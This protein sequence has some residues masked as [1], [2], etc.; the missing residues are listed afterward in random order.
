MNPENEQD[1][2]DALRRRCWDSAVHCFGTSQIFLSRSKRLT[3]NLRLLT[4]LGLAAPLAVG[5]IVA[6]FGLQSTIAPLALA[7]AAVVGIFQVIVFAWSVVFSWVDRN[8]YAKESAVA[9]DDLSNRFSRLGATPPSTLHEMQAAVDIV[10][11]EDK[12]RR[13]RDS[14]AHMSEAEN[15]MG[16]RAG[17]RQFQRSCI[18]CGEVPTTMTSTD[19]DVCGRF[20]LK[21][22]MARS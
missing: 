19:C 3:R 20:A 8:V 10:E 14:E 22:R 2:Y 5:T 16:M 18:A 7:I 13:Q 17:L 1:R 11:T 12:L 9:N 6:A 21:N 15:R 4:Y